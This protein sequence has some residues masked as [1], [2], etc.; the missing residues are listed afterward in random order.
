MPNAEATSGPDGLEMPID[1]PNDL[2]CKSD[3]IASTLNHGGVRRTQLICYGDSQQAGYTALLR[4]ASNTRF[5]KR[6]G[7][8]EPTSQLRAHQL[9]LVELTNSVKTSNTSP[10]H[11]EHFIES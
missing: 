11:R 2:L 10:R 9:A 1:S 6:C 8:I 3:S 5:R 7:N 4:A